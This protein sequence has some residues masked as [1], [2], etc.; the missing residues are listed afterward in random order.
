M[1]PEDFLCKPCSLRFTNESIFQI[2]LSVAGLYQGRNYWGGQ[3]ANNSYL[4][5][6]FNLTAPRSQNYWGGR[7]PPGSPV[8]TAL[9]WVEVEECGLKIKAPLPLPSTHV[10][11]EI[12]F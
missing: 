12:V 1:N 8:D 5:Q 4:Y 11:V 3:K 6:N 2:H 7:G 10:K 9:T